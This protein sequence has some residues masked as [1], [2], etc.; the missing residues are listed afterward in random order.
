[1]IANDEDLQVRPRD[2]G[3]GWV[4]VVSECGWPPLS[5]LAPNRKAAERSGVFASSALAALARIGRRR[6]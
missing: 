3:G 6:F 5:G 2:D 1:M 4:W